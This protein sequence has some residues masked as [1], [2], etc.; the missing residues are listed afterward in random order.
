MTGAKQE[1]ARDVRYAIY[2]APAPG[3]RWWTFGC[4]WLGYD[5]QACVAVRQ[6][7]IPDV[8]AEG[9]AALTRKAWRYGFHGTLKAPMRLAVGTTETRLA[10]ALERIAAAREPF[11]LPRMEVRRLRGFLACMTAA[12]DDRIHALADDCVRELDPF[13]APPTAAEI[14]RRESNGLSARQSELLGRWGYPY[15]FDEF[16]FHMTLTGPLA[17]VL[18]QVEIAVTEAAAAAIETLEDEPLVCDAVSLFV[19]I[20]PEGPFRLRRRFPFGPR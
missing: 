12:A 1:P 10:E 16:R 3:S 6:P 11:P 8:P 13:R 14:A 4:S 9:F 19:Q 5:P 17:D 2:F 7:D 15:V 20:A 18:P